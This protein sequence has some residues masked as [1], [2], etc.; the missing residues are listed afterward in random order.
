MNDIQT[1]ITDRIKIL[2]IDDDLFQLQLFQLKFK[3][4]FEVLIAEFGQNGLEILKNNKDIDVVISDYEMP[5]MSGLEFIEKAREIKNDIPFY[6][7]SC[8]HKTTEI[9]EAL[10]NKLI[11]YFFSK[12]INKNDL[13]NEVCDF[14]QQ[15]HINV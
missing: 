12:P 4:R 11:D 3:S 10:Q 7:F 6:I 1:K 8:S 9:R 15:K 5:F 2:Y 13:L 14:Y